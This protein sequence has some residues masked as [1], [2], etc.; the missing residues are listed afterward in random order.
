[1]RNLGYKELVPPIQRGWKRHFELRE[2]VATGM[3]RDF[4]LA[5]LEKVN[6]VEYSHRK[7][8]KFKRKRKGKKVDVVRTQSLKHF[9]EWDYPRL[10]LTDKQKLYFHERLWLTDK[11]ELRKKYFF[12]EPWRYILKVRPNLITRIKIID[13][14][15]LQQESEISTYLDKSH[16]RPRFE[17]LIYGYYTWSNK[18]ELKPKMKYVSLVPV[19]ELVAEYYEERE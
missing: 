17:R 8:F 1:M 15:L 4:F 13:P 12:A 9:Y 6:T 2:D 18:W 11:G 10:K 16:L 7:D 14:L 3:D 5:L 19:S